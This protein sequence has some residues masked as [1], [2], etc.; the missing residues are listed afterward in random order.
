[1]DALTL[2]KNDHR[3]V[4]KLFKRFEHTGERAFAERRKIVDRIIE[5][6]SQH[7][8]IEEQV[9]YPVVLATVRGANDMALE[10]LE[11]HHVVKWLLSELRGMDPHAERFEARV[12]VLIESVRHHVQDEETELFPKVR[13][14]LSRADLVE[15]GDELAHARGR[16]PTHPHPRSPDT[17]PANLVTDT[18]A[19]VIDK[20]SDTIG[21]IAQGGVGAVQDLI[22]RLTDGSRP[23]SGP[24]GTTRSR[25]QA[26]HVR[27]ASW[28]AVDGVERTVKSAGRGARSTAKTVR[29]GARSTATSARRGTRSTAKAASNSAKGT[30]RTARSSAKKT[31]STAK[32]ASTTTGRTAAASAKRTK[33]TAKRNVNRTRSA[34]RSR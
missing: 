3:S 12:T 9:F 20:V 28:A 29:S 21:G 4:E 13:Q 19:G 1:M 30:A 7:A 16:A 10:S 25:T 14:Q 32:R 24:T 2:L 34:A 6:L 11:E 8:A 26:R 33:A 17:P 15:V 27:R 31:V 23:T 5:E 22:A 18:A